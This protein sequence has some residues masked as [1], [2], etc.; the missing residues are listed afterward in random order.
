MWDYEAE[1][2]PLPEVGW[3]RSCW[4]AMVIPPRLIVT[5]QVEV[6]PCTR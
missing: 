6:V 3:P 1:D 4:T 5:T 2:E